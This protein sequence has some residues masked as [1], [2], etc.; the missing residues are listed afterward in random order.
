MNTYWAYLSIYINELLNHHVQKNQ[1]Q[2]ACEMKT[3]MFKALQIDFYTNMLKILPMELSNL[4]I[5]DSI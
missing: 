4:K 2:I 5:S 3:V 1:E